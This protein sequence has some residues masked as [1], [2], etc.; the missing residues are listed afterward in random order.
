VNKLGE[1]VM[2]RPRRRRAIVAEQ[3]EPKDYIVPRY[4]A[5]QNAI[6]DYLVG[7]SEPELIAARTL[8]AS[9]ECQRL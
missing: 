6:T 5:A 1:Y 4:S 7:N 8:L 3:K 9:G 2:A